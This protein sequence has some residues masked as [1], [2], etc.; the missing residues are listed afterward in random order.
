LYIQIK[1]YYW[2]KE[3]DPNNIQGFVNAIS[4]SSYAHPIDTAAKLHAMKSMTDVFVYHFGYHGKNSHTSLDINNY[5]PKVVEKT[6]RYG[7][8]NGDDL[9]YLFPV[10][11]GTFRP[12]PHE[13]LVFSE[14]FIKLFTSFAKNGKPSLQMEAGHE[15]VW[16]PVKATNATHLNIGTTFYYFWP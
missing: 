11:S 15:F 9:I 13:D 2:G 6:I 4:D 3:I 8:G 16:D 7:V 12:L 1:D 10:L 14:R 5:P